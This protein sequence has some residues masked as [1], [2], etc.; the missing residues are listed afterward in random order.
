M[1]EEADF[2]GDWGFVG[3]HDFAGL[4]DL[5]RVDCDKQAA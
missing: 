3:G 4:G 1:G 2:G 5:V